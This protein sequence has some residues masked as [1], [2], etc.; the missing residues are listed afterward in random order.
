[1]ETDPGRWL[2]LVEKLLER[3]GEA[4]DVA[5]EEH[6]LFASLSVDDVE[7]AELSDR[8]R[9][10]EGFHDYKHSQSLLIE[11]KWRTVLNILLFLPILNAA[12][13]Y[14]M[15]GVTKC[16]F[17]TFLSLSRISPAADNVLL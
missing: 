13:K 11:K 12:T 6:R 8:R 15:T 3:K 10:L 2:S 16:N 14:G 1:M 17:T 7:L 5:C 9:G 4:T